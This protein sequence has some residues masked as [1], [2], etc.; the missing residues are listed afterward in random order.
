M[1]QARYDKLFV[2]IDVPKSEYT[3]ADI[4]PSCEVPCPIGIGL[5]DNGD[6]IREPSVVN[7]K[8]GSGLQV[9]EYSLCRR[10]IYS[11]KLEIVPAKS[12]DAEG[13]IR[14]NSECRIHE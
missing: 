12:G 3:S 9:S 13:D 2:E 6:R 8:S 10:C 1:N 14:S 5:S 7:S 11:E 4:F